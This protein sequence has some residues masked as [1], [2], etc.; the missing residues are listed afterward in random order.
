[1]GGVVC[2]RGLAR[3]R[4]DGRACV[5]VNATSLLLQRIGRVLFS[6]I[7]ASLIDYTRSGSQ[8]ILRLPAANGAEVGE[9]AALLL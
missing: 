1:M 6:I 3:V 5:C 7:I 4:R 9:A 2:W 8:N